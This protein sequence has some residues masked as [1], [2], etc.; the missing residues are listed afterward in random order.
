[1]RIHILNMKRKKDDNRNKEMKRE[2]GKGKDISR[3]IGGRQRRWK[4]D[5]VGQGLNLYC[6]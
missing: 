1:M 3:K 5:K 2:R 4:I 6:N